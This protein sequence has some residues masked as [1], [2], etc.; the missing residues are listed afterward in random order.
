[1]TLASKLGPDFAES[2]ALSGSVDRI[3]SSSRKQ[4]IDAYG[5]ETELPPMRPCL[6]YGRHRGPAR[7]GARQAAVA[8]CLH[9]DSKNRWVIPL[10][11]RPSALRH[12]GGQICLPGG[13]IESGEQ[14]DTA[15]LREFEEE[16]G[17]TPHVIKHYGELS[18]TY[19]YASDNEV[20]PV[21]FMIDQPNTPWQPDPVEVDEVILLPLEQ[22]FRRESRTEYQ[23]RRKVIFKKPTARGGRDSENA[24]LEFTAPAFFWGGYQ[25]WG[26]TAIILDELAQI[27]LKSES[28]VSATANA[29]TPN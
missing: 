28:F 16:L 19:V 26:A 15:A 20:H 24:Y 6:A 18:K 8:I 22:L 1:M 12:H 2:L 21:I 13:Q 17:V 9:Q 29:V 3:A 23:I 5:V 7:S 27:L 14:A 10:T 4:P 25:I 11:R